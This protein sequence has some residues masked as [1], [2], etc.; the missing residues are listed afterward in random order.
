M[1]CCLASLQWP[2]LRPTAM[3]GKLV[4]HQNQ[5]A[6]VSYRLHYDWAPWHHCGAQVCDWY[7]DCS[8]RALQPLLLWHGRLLGLC[9]GLKRPFL[10]GLAVGRLTGDVGCSRQHCLCVTVWCY[11]FVC[12]CSKQ[13]LRASISLQVSTFANLIL[14]ALSPFIKQFHSCWKFVTCSS[15]CDLILLTL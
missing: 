13:T 4:T 15:E 7:L 5:S 1:S 8:F 6:K 9:C 12:A 10:A 2:V 11:Y 14:S 3:L